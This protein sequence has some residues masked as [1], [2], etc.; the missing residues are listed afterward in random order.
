MRKLAVLALL[1]IVGMGLLGTLWADE[2]EPNDSWSTANEINPGTHLGNVSNSDDW[3]R[4]EVP[5]RGSI[6]VNLYFDDSNGGDL[7]LYLIDIDGSRQLDDS[8]SSS[9]NER[10]ARNNLRGG[11]Y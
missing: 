4:V 6:R 11:G 7:D 1:A 3:F 2:S 9:D 10:V 5:S 8:D